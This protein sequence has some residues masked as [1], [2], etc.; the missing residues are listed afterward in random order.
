MIFD[1]SS[2]TTAAVVTQHSRGWQPQR[3]CLW[4]LRRHLLAESGS[5]EQRVRTAAARCV[6]R[7]SRRPRTRRPSV[8]L[9]AY[10]GGRRN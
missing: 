4:P 5:A 8:A 1:D 9:A 6:D 2:P 3:R 10:R 7:A